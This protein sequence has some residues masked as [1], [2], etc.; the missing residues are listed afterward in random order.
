MGFDL[1]DDDSKSLSLDDLKKEFASDSPPRKSPW[2]N[3]DE[4]RFLLDLFNE[5]KVKVLRG[6]VRAA[7]MRYDWDGINGREC[8][9]NAKNYIHELR[10]K[11]VTISVAEQSSRKRGLIH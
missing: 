8:V 4:L 9:Q 11:H 2:S 7:A 5:G 1:L 6:Y 3:S 10:T